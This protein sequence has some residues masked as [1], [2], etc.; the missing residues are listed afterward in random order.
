MSRISRIAIGQLC[1]SSSLSRNL[2]TVKRLIGKAIDSEAQVIFFPEATDY[3]AKNAEHSKKLAYKSPLFV[4]ELRGE[5]KNVFEKTSRKIDVA[6]GVH[7]PPTVFEL[8][9]GEN[10]VK[11]VLLYIDYKG[12]IVQSYQ[13][14]HLFDVDVPNGPVMLES[15][16]VQPGNKYADVVETPAGKLG[17]AICYDIRFPE[18]S[19]ELRARGAEVLCFPSAFTMRTGEAHWELLGKAR[20]IDTQSF[21]IMPAQNGQHDVMADDDG[22]ISDNIT[23]RISWGHSMVIDPWGQVIARASQVGES[24]LL[25]A[26]LDYGILERVRT[27]MPLTQQRSATNK[28][29]QTN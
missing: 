13:K 7:L 17:L 3:I 9:K 23:S 11:N 4:E 25:I 14:V 29:L 18:Q 1:S 5:I 27:N 8:E 26:E 16:S 22:A 28:L 2:E 20:A 10:R 15:K 19:L 24:E 12:D 21:V 6:I